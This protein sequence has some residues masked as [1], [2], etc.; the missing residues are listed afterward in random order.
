L[1]TIGRKGGRKSRRVL[2]PQ[3]ARSMVRLR[4]AKRAYR[5][6]YAQCFWSFDP[7]LIIT[8]DDIEWV[9]E[10]LKRN[11]NLETWRLGVKLCR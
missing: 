3:K 11:G 1:S 9:A 4:E 6:Y 10:Q 7:D 5:K 2:D 8:K